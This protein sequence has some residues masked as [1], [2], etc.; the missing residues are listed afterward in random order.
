MLARPRGRRKDRSLKRGDVTSGLR[1]RGFG[2]QPRARKL[3]WEVGGIRLETS[4][5]LFAPTKT[6]HRPQFSGICVENRGV[7]FHR[8]RDFKQYHFNS[9]PPTS[10]NCRSTSRR[11]RFSAA[12]RFDN[13]R[14]QPWQSRPVSLSH[15][16]SV[17]PS[18][19]PVSF[20]WLLFSY[21]FVYL[22][23]C[24][25]FDCCVFLP[26][27]HLSL[28]RRFYVAKTAWLLWVMR[29]VRR[30]CAAGDF[31]RQETRY[32]YLTICIG[33]F[34]R[35]ETGYSYLMMFT[36]LALRSL[37]PSRG[38]EGQ[39]WR[40]AWWAGRPSGP[41][42]QAHRAPLCMACDVLELFVYILVEMC[43]YIYVLLC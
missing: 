35:Q 15:T 6:Y 25:V 3:T 12:A 36:L 22:F 34:L 41:A 28:V 21:L 18:R 1:Q 14:A 13:R 2:C 9:I 42:G 29:P 32:L 40:R 31:L 23:S 11:D 8:T 38:P 16:L 4:S 19:P 30:S 43:C 33:D 27:S 37:G 5:K 39:S 24:Y 20:C 7:R 26:P 17:P 10:H